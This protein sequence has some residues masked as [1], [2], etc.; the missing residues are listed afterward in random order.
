[1]NVKKFFGFFFLQWLIFAFVKVWLLN[2]QI[3]SSTNIQNWVYYFIIAVVT[4]ALFRRFGIITYIEAGFALVFYTFGTLF[5]DLVIT[6]NYTS[7]SLFKSV[8]YWIGYVVM[9]LAAMIFHKKRHVYLRRE[10][11]AQHHDHHAAQEHQD[12]KSHGDHHQQNHGQHP[13]GKHH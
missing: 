3:F 11:H 6:S 10:L 9:I 13:P 12:H 7:L 4:V 2:G 1:M 5:L 8:T